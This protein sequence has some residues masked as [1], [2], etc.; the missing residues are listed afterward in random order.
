[1]TA[2]T[3]ARVSSATSGLPLR[4]FETVGT[5]TPVSTA[6]LAM[7]TRGPIG[8]TFSEFD[9]IAGILRQFRVN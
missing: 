3:R 9:G 2:S 7:V 4:T 1:M 5:E 6:I 8:S